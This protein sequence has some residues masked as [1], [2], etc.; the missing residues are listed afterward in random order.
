[1]SGRRIVQAVAAAFLGIAAGGA[2]LI[3]AWGPTVTPYRL[4][5]FLGCMFVLTGTVVVA[6]ILWALE[7][8]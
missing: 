1:M 4:L 6:V 2:V 8:P 3:L 5:G 7:K